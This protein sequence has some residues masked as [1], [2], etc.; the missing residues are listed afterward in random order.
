MGRVGV[1]V[2]KHLHWV[3]VREGVRRKVPHPRD[4]P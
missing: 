1:R 4:S 2:R 3:V